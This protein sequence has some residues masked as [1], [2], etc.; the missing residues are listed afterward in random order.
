MDSGD[1]SKPERIGDRGAHFVVELVRRDP[2]FL[3]D[4]KHHPLIDTVILS[5][6]GENLSNGHKNNPKGA[7]KRWVDQH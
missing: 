2:Y 6:T 5:N 3:G 7:A 4:E 1:P